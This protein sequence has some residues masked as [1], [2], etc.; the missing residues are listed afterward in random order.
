MKPDPRN[1]GGRHQVLCEVAVHKAKL[2]RIRSGVTPTWRGRPGRPTSRGATGGRSPSP[3]PPST[4]S[5]RPTSRVGGPAPLFPELLAEVRVGLFGVCNVV[6]KG[7]GALRVN[8][9]GSVGGGCRWACACCKRPLRCCPVWWASLRGWGDANRAA[10]RVCAR[11]AALARA[12]F[13]SFETCRRGVLGTRARCLRVWWTQRSRRRSG[14][15]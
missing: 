6:Q 4:T 12:V 14:G 13:F 1:I 9:A 10:C 8:G 15:R 2:A 7:R 11:R 5:P 3:R